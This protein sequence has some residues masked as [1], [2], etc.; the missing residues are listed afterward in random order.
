M[1][2][3]VMYAPGGPDVLQ[4]RL[5]DDPS[6]DADTVLI[7]VVA[8]G[9]NPYDTKVR[10]GQIP[11]RTLPL[12][13]GSD[14]SGVVLESRSEKFSVGDEVFGISATGAYAQLG[15]C[16]IVDLA[17]KPENVS[18]EAAAGVPVP[19]VTAWQSLFEFGQLKQGQTLIVAG[20]AGGVGQLAVQ[21]GKVAGATVVG[22][23]RD[24]NRDLVL[25]L[26][27][28]EFIDYTQVNVADVVHADLVLDCV[29][30]RNSV[31]LAEAVVDGGRLASL[32]AP[33]PEDFQAPP[34]ITVVR[35]VRHADA[36]VLERIASLM[37]SGDVHV[38]VGAR[39]DLPDA[40]HAQALVETGHSSGKTI[41]TIG[42]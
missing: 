14:V 3:V 40:S 37:S 34:E 8:A 18:H 4:Y 7:R 17:R 33:L 16:P 10:S 11:A 20:A 23:A 26:G 41:L 35:P 19:G 42:N 36:S 29:G 32:G 9:V 6:P 31:S 21:F 15:V 13:L 39:F 22:I 1:F 30:G 2:A 5:V 25:G 38:H 12:I 27:A 28:D 24:V